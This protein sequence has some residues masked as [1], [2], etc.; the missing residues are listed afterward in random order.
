MSREVLVSWDPGLRE[1]G[2]AVFVNG[3]LSEVF[4]VYADT[5]DDGPRQWVAMA[6]A[7][8]TRCN[9]CDVFAFEQMQTRRGYEA[10]HDN[11]VE[12]SIISGMAAG[13]MRCTVAAVPANT[14]T[15]GRKKKVNAKLVR[16]Q[17]DEA[18]EAVLDAA[19][20]ATKKTNHKELYDAVG[21]GLY[22]LRRWQ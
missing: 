8:Y 6:N 19:I 9:G 4:A 2:A 17:L 13:M 21:I 11:L 5:Q 15:R 20:D 14:W 12:L 16:H 10:S 1:S 18:E 22:Q 7:V 3:E